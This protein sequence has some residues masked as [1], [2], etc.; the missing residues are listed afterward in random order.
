MKIKRPTYFPLVF[1][2]LSACF[3]IIVTEIPIIET[4][5]ARAGRAASAN[6]VAGVGHRTIRRTHR[7]EHRRR[8]RIGTRVV[9]LPS[10]CRTVISRSVKYY[11][12]GGIYYRPYYQGTDLVFVIVED[13]T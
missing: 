8:V 13:P 11:Y 10:N 3:L 2:L 1:F 5:E 6:R 9:A 4:V 12:C 7:R